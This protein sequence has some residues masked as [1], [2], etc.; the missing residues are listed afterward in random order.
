[1]ID[2]NCVWKRTIDKIENIYYATKYGIENLINWF[3]VI[4]QDRNWDHYFIYVILQKKLKLMEYQ[5]RYLGHHTRAEEDANNIKICVNLLDRLIKDEYHE[6]AFKRHDEKWGEA[7]FRFEDCEDNPNL[8]SLNIDRENVKTEED[9]EK[10]RK[11]FRKASEHEAKLR[12]QDLDMLF[13]YMRKYIQT[14]WD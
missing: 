14:W 5:I 10:E 9:K 8:C 13:S 12:E 6:N 7:D 3:P 2:W 4:W 1:M 11:E